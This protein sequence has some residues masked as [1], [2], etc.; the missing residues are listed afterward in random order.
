M[1]DARRE[2]ADARQ[3]L[4]LADFFFVGDF[5]SD[6]FD[7]HDA[8]NRCSRGFALEQ[9]IELDLERM[10]RGSAA[11]LGVGDFP[12]E[13]MARMLVW[14]GSSNS[15]SDSSSILRPSTA[16]LLARSIQK[17]P[18]GLFDHKLRVNDQY[19]FL[20]RIEYLI[21]VFFYAR[22]FLNVRG[23]GAAVFGKS[24]PPIVEALEEVGNFAF[25]RP[26]R[27]V[28]FFARFEAQHGLAKL[29][30]GSVTALLSRRS[31]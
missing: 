13:M 12:P 20:N 24:G 5:G 8:V 6:I 17:C 3:L 25:P 27:G 18:V 26:G 31:I 21:V 30:T 14:T 9:W 28:G 10:A 29:L 22:D 23:K 1:C 7:D 19:F 2:H 4:G 16:S 15:A 11:N